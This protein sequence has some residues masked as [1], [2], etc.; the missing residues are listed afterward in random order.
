MKHYHAI[1]RLTYIISDLNK[2]IEDLENLDSE[3]EGYAGYVFV[4]EDIKNLT[5]EVNSLRETMKDLINL[6]K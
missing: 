6:S 1:V 5:D 3:L 2:E 4:Q